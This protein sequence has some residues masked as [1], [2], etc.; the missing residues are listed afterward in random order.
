[1]FSI[2]VIGQLK[3]RQQ[4]HRQRIIRGPTTTTT[5]TTRTN[6]A[7]TTAASII[8]WPL[9]PAL[10]RPIRS[11]VEVEKILSNDDNNG[12]SRRGDNDWIA[13]EKFDGERTLVVYNR[14]TFR[15]YTRTLLERMDLHELNAYLPVAATDY[16]LDAELVCVDEHTDRIIALNETGQ[17]RRGLCRQLRVFDILSLNSDTTIW[18][19]PLS[20]RREVL[21]EL[22]QNNERV[23]I[24][25]WLPLSRGIISLRQHYSE[26]VTKCGGEGLI[27]KRT[28]QA[29]ESNQRSWLKIK[30]WLLQGD[31]DEYDV[32]AIRALPDYHGHAV[33]SLECRQLSNATRSIKCHV[34]SGL[35]DQVRARIRTLLMEDGITIRN[36]GI[37]CTI[38]A[39]RCR[40]LP[41]PPP[42]PSQSNTDDDA[43]M[44]LRHPVF[45]RLRP[46]LLLYSQSVET[47][48]DDNYDA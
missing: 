43:T 40:H 35:T 11:W 25:P 21:I 33:G 2:R 14:G 28:S 39:D 26:I 12:R 1:M 36:G 16:T 23:R 18:A 8:M 38:T 29:Y 15:W 10:A 19:W 13:E 37:P 9:K 48:Q 31:R 24:V 27:L 45:L 6:D 44:S 41:P 42:P 22:L 32:L 7:S 30:P 46:D 17:N 3:K 47:S 5:T 4:R 34:A 20:R